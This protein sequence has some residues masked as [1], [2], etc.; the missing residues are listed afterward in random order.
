MALSANMLRYLVKTGERQNQQ[1]VLS[2][3][4][5]GVDAEGSW[6][7]FIVSKIVVDFR[8]ENPNHIGERPYLLVTFLL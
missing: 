4:G 3:G 1:W 5:G 6:C 2:L 8:K 7:Q